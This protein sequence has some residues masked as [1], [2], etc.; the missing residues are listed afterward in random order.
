[1]RCV[2]LFLTHIQIGLRLEPGDSSSDGYQEQAVY[3]MFASAAE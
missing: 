3:E 1:M 2:L